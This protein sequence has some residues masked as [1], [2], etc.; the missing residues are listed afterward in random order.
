MACNKTPRRVE[1]AE[2]QFGGKLATAYARSR[3]M[4]LP[5]P[6]LIDATN[7]ISGLLTECGVGNFRGAGNRFGRREFLERLSQPIHHLIRVI[8][9]GQPS[10]RPPTGRA[11]H[12]GNVVQPATTEPFEQLR[13]AIAVFLRRAQFQQ[14][15][16]RSQAAV[17]VRLRSSSPERGIRVDQQVLPGGNPIGKQKAI[18]QALAQ[19]AEHLPGRAAD[20]DE[21]RG[22]ASQL[23][24]SA[25][26]G[27]QPDGTGAVRRTRALL[28]CLANR[29]EHDRQIVAAGNAHGL[30]GGSLFRQTFGGELCGASAGQP[31]SPWQS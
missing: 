28:P 14:Q 15:R 22:R 10:Q 11:R 12:A 25:S 13:R 29:G 17:G 18:F 2:V 5:V 9:Q 7:T 21:Q 31:P 24:D 4:P 3:T 6:P 23:S 16:V 30:G 19:P 1:G 27:R 26:K 8:H 20:A